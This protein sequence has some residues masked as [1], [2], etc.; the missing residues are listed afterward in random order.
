MVKIKSKKFILIAALISIFLLSAVIIVIFSDDKSDEITDKKHVDS[1][2]NKQVVS[3]SSEETEMA[4]SKTESSKKI[5]VL[6]I[7][8][9]LHL[10]KISLEF[11]VVIKKLYFKEGQQIRQNDKLAYIS[12]DDFLVSIKQNELILLEAELDLTR[13]KNRYDSLKNELIVIQ[14]EYE[15][16]RKTYTSSEDLLKL[17][18]IS[19]SEFIKIK[20][21]LKKTELELLKVQQSLKQY[22][23]TSTNIFSLLNKKI[24]NLEYEIQK[25]QK[26]L[27]N[28]YLSGNFIIS[29]YKNGIVHDISVKEGDYLEPYQMVCH[30]SDFDSMIVEAYVPEEYLHDIKVD[31][32]VEVIPI[33]KQEIE[34]EGKIVRIFNIAQKIV[35][36][37]TIIIEI[38]FISKSRSLI[39]NLNVDVNIFTS[40]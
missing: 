18:G 4:F 38:G 13:E 2:V 16:Q 25:K 22:Q 30:V 1:F 10:A 37:T 17:G 40:Q 27:K 23:D 32:H 24:S 14:N 5:E 33:S 29:P 26:K 20:N 3:A 11:P 31:N 19:E 28:E 9:S 34:L 36:E 8:K 6:G 35:G 12:Y 39:P 21:Q 15:E 7:I